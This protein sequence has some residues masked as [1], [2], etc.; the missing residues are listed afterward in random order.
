MAAWELAKTGYD[1]TIFEAEAVAGGMLAWGI[2]AYRLPKDIL[3]EEIQAIK[4]LGVK[5]QLNTRIGQDLSLEDLQA[6]GFKAIFIATGAPK[7]LSLGIPGEKHE[8]ILDPIEFLKAFNLG[9]KVR[10]GKRVAVIGGGNTAIDAARTAWRLGA[11][12]TILYRRTRN[13]MPA[14]PEEIEEALAEGIRIEYLTLPVEA[15]PENGQLNKLKCQRMVLKGFDESGRPRPVAFEGEILEVA[16]DTLIPAIGQVP[17]LS[18]LGDPPLL[19]VSRHRTLEVDQETMATNVPGI[20]AGGDVV[21][22][23]ATVLEAMKSGKV[24]AASI[25]RYLRGLPLRKEPSIAETQFE[26]PPVEISEEEL[27]SLARPA[28]P[29]LPVPGRVGNFEEVELGLSREMALR[30]ARRCLRCDLESIRLR[31]ESK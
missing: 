12:V 18:F 1:V 31:G 2:P 27:A 16:C 15:C 7:N 29:T 10:L 28:M 13:E 25:H 14:I 11:D 4:A 23:P 3:Q 9:K 22:G 26:V 8:G 19:K 21:S 6:Q 17:D 20:F 24:A 5:I 30:E